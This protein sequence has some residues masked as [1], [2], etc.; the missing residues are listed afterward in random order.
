VLLL[1]SSSALGEDFPLEEYE[2]H[3]RQFLASLEGLAFHISVTDQT[4]DG[5]TTIRDECDVISIPK[6]FRVKWVTRVTENEHLVRSRS[7]WVLLR[8]DAYYE[9]GEKAEG[10]FWLKGRQ[11][12]VKSPLAVETNTPLNFMI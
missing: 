4:L 1:P 5:K 6:H 8:P 2:T 9:I 3:V 7:E 12:G 10:Q 11:K